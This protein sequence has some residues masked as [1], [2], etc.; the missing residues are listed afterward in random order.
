MAANS[1][2]VWTCSFDLPQGALPDG[3]GNYCF[4]DASSCVNALNACNAPDPFLGN[5]RSGNYSASLVLCQQNPATCATGV[6]AGS[7][8]V[9][10]CP[11]DPP[12]GSLPTG[13]GELCYD[14]CA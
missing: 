11:L 1:G 6:A 13:S 2:N 8:N 9:W 4:Q 7:G 14:R 10:T 3:A 5:L 12:M